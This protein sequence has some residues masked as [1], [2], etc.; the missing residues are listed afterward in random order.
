MLSVS[1]HLQNILTHWLNNPRL[2][3]YP[4]EI[5]AYFH[6]CLG[7]MMFA[8]MLFLIVQNQFDR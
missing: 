1:E 2:E 4:R 7:I 5:I 3:I 6:K 8:Q